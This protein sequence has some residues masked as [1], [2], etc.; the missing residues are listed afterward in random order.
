MSAPANK[1]ERLALAAAVAPVLRRQTESTKS[2]RVKVYSQETGEVV[3]EA[4]LAEVQAGILA[5]A[6]IELDTAEG[7]EETH[8]EC[9]LCG[10]PFAIDRKRPNA[11]TCARCRTQQT[12]CAGEGCDAVPPRGA[13]AFST[14]VGRKGAP[15]MCF[16]CQRATPE[17]REKMAEANRRKYDDPAFRA[18]IAE[19]S[20]RASGTPEWRANVTEAQRRRR[21][22]ER[23]K[24]VIND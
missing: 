17:W 10:V 18:K 7:V 8:R 5:T 4:T 22:S 14:V 20:R 3:T 24:A 16:A 15:W 23:T 9:A 13:F 1:V 12:K 21:E 6:R 11:K 19:A 2:R